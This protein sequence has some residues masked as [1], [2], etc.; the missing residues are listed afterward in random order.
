[1][2]AT[3]LTTLA[4]TT[5]PIVP[6]S[7]S[8]TSDEKLSV[9]KVDQAS[10]EE[11]SVS[12]HGVP[13]LIHGGP[14]EEETTYP[15][16]GF[17]AWSTVVGAFLLQFTC[18]SYVNTF[19]V[20]HQYYVQN[21]LTNYTPSD[22]GWI[23]GIQV[24]F[25]FA[26]GALTGRLFDKG[27]FRYL[28]LGAIFC[29]AF[30]VFMLSLT[31]PNAYYQVFLTHGLFVGLAGGLSFVP[32]ISIT[33]SHFHKRRALAVGIVCSG[34]SIGGF[35]HPLLLNKLFSTS[36]GFHNGVRISAG[37][38]TFL[39]IIAFFLMRT[40]PLH[41]SVGPELSIWRYF[42]EPAYLSFLIGG[43]FVYLGIFL[44]LFDVQLFAVTHGM[45]KTFAFYTTSILNASFAFGMVAPGLFRLIP[46]FGV[47]NLTTFF[48]LS[49]GVLIYAMAA[50][51]SKGALIIFM[52]LFGSLA[53]ASLTTTPTMLAFLAK[54][55]REI[56]SRLG[57]FY[58]IGGSIGLFSSPVSGALLTSDYHWVRPCIFD[59]T[60]VFVGG[61]FFGIARTLYAREHKSQR[62]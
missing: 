61:L 17:W 7:R 25:N 21:Y 50:V 41:K 55:P 31:H 35:A 37:M 51:N 39:L 4:S 1:M 20:Y 8:S 22:I 18:F 45:D 3:A 11:K 9:D 6:T 62:V 36:I 47:L 52:I 29:H 57:V 19:G 12:H 16:G 2:A 46:I 49:S 24:F 59:G 60:M 23:G 34:G 27:Y 33:G 43:F 5:Q 15:D 53:G 58:A 30:G 42:K 54:D 13:E 10:K 32:S 56:G 26:I 48:T 38:N 44:P 40:R 28:T 14:E